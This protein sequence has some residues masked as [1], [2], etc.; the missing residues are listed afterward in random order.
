MRGRGGRAA[1]VSGCTP[2]AVRGLGWL[3]VRRSEKLD[4]LMV[5]TIRKRIDRVEKGRREVL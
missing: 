1:L 3:C 5:K 2:S 4:G